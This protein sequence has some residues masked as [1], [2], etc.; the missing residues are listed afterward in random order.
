MKTDP[1][2]RQTTTTLIAG[3]PV[4]VALPSDVKA[5]SDRLRKQYFKALDNLKDR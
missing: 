4:Q 1:K 2:K 3:K 5:S